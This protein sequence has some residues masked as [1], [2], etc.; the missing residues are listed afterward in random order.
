MHGRLSTPHVSAERKDG[1]LAVN[2]EFGTID[3]LGNVTSVV[4]YCR[5][6]KKGDDEPKNGSIVGAKGVKQQ[7]VLLDKQLGSAQF[8]LDDRGDDELLVQASYLSGA[9]K[10]SPTRLVRYPL[11]ATAIAANATPSNTTPSP[12]ERVQPGGDTRIIPERA[13][14]PFRDEGPKDALLVGLEIGLTKV[15]TR[16]IL[17]AV[18][19]IYRSGASESLGQVHGPA[20]K[21]A[22]EF[23]AKDGYA[24]G[25]ITVK[26]GLWVESLKIRFMRVAGGKLNPADSYESVWIGDGGGTETFLSGDGSQLI[27]VIG[28]TLPARVGGF[29]VMAKKSN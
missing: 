3:P 9:P 18:R 21:I 26:S 15:G 8:M 22:V 7:Y 12:I 5:S 24:V 10:P 29:G 1:K 11:S 16:D 27:G 19:P 4:V 13:G 20:P 6:F 17:N 25:G 14:Q 23:K 2:V 28:R